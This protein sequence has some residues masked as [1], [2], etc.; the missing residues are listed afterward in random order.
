MSAE[1]Y[2]DL[3]FLP[4]PIYGD[5]FSWLFNLAGRALVAAL[6]VYYES[7]ADLAGDG[8]Y[9]PGRL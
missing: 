6:G 1:A 9:A 4:D 5:I 7:A 8:L 3:D 2:V